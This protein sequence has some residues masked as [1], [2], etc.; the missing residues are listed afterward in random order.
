MPIKL[1]RRPQAKRRIQP[2][3][4]KEVKSTFKMLGKRVD[5]ALT[6]E[7]ADWE[8]QPKFG[9]NS[10]VTTKEWRMTFYHDKNSEAGRIYDWVSNGTGSRGDDPNGKTYF[11][12]PKHAK[13]L[14]FF[15][16]MELKT[17]AASNQFAPSF[18]AAPQ[19]VLTKAVKAPGI[20]P[21]HLGW[22]MWEYLQSRKSGSF[23]NEIEAAIKRA[24]RRMGIYVG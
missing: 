1:I 10:K 3:V 12:T 18:Y 20:Y 19:E 7:I 23:H 8:H 21:R 17:I 24:F 4:L 14:H 9:Y 16:P 15:L 5:N 6:K 2:E 22:S 13:A 11:I